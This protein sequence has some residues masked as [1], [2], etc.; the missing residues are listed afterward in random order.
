MP[1]A[2]DLAT[3]EERRLEL[4]RFIERH[5]PQGSL[6]NQVTV[7]FDGNPEM[8]GGM[9][10]PA[11]KVIFSQ[12][13]SADDKIKE[14]VAHTKNVKNVIV[15]SDDRDIQYAVRALG[16]KISTAQEFLGRAKVSLKDGP[17]GPKSSGK[18][19]KG[20]GFGHQ[21]ESVKHIS[22]VEEARITSELGK[23]WLSPGKKHNK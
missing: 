21:E 6:N 8:Y 5:R 3:L 1:W 18:N 10:S 23:I 17:I 7:V 16:A 20:S 12:G 19:K 13:E 14:I 22:K 2:L 4:I 15:V 11:A 9:T